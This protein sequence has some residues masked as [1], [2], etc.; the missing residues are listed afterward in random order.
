MTTSLN[1]PNVDNCLIGTGK[2]YMKFAADSDYV[3]VGNCKSFK[4]TPVFDVIE[5]WDNQGASRTLD[6][7]AVAKKSAKMEIVMEEWT[8]RNMSLLLAGAV[9]LSGST[10]TI[11]IMSADV[12]PAAVKYVAA[13]SIGPQWTFVY[14]R[15]EFAPKK[16]LDPLSENWAPLDAEGEVIQVG[17]VF[18]TATCPFAG[19]AVPVNT[20]LPVIITDGSPAI[21]ETLGSFPGVWSGT[22]TFA[23]Q[24]K[25]DGV[26][27]S[28]ATAST[29]LVVSGDTGDAI[30]LTITATNAAGSASATSAAVSIP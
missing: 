16:A 1:S 28:G 24:W 23:Y 10:A 3:R 7:T 13:N 12:I 30:T 6:K 11:D 25:D 15:V 5:H 21:G 20:V 8:A 17:G 27:I 26:A 9:V 4:V 18:G 19:D 29:Y 2:V 14:P 22:P